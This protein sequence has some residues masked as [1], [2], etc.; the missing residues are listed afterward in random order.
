MLPIEVRQIMGAYRTDEQQT[1]GEL[2][3]ILAN[4]SS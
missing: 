2:R 1:Q 4:L 3:A